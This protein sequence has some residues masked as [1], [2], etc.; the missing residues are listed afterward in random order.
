[1]P[2]LSSAAHPGLGW[3]GGCRHQTWALT[4]GAPLAELGGAN[5]QGSQVR[6]TLGWAQV[7]HTL[8]WAGGCRHQGLSGAA[9]PR[10][11]PCG[12][13]W[14]VPTPRA[15]KCG[16]PW[17]G[18]GGAP[19]SPRR[20]GLKEAAAAPA[21][22]QLHKHVTTLTLSGS[23]PILALLLHCGGRAKRQAQRQRLPCHYAA[24]VHVRSTGP[25]SRGLVAVVAAAHHSLL[26]IRD[27]RNRGQLVAR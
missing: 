10:V 14:V 15:L 25:I 3:A 2:G 21:L 8:G 4:S 16:T 18:L 17:A 7:R 5:T 24:C 19:P 9:H 26:S 23:L 11:R 12:L 20:L 22:T 13:G 6:C 1:M 27:R